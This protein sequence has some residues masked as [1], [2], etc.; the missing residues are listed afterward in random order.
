ME[1]AI[2]GAWKDVL[3]IE[4][5]GIHDNF[6]EIGGQSLLATQII[7]RLR[8]LTKKEI[9]LAVLFDYPTISELSE[10]LLEEEELLFR[11]L[12][13]QRALQYPD[14]VF[15]IAPESGKQL[16]Y[17]ELRQ[18]ARE[19]AIQ[20]ARLNFSKGDKFAVLSQNGFFPAI[21][22]FGGFYGGFVPVPLN[23]AAAHG[24]NA[25]MVS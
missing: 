18:K 14:R 19:F 17:F 1:R 11:D 20:L 7:V 22:L 25:H 2:A 16:T 24:T 15:L 8:N 9:P 10:R 3:K 21:S 5:L 4:K 13:D 23:L 12:I 6:F